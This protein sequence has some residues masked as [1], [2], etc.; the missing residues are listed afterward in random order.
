[1]ISIVLQ[2]C[3]VCGRVSIVSLPCDSCDRTVMS[4]PMTSFRRV[5]GVR[6]QLMEIVA[7]R[8]L[9]ERNSVIVHRHVL[10]SVRFGSFGLVRRSSGRVD[11]PSHQPT[12]YE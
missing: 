5:S 10:G 6:H 3:D 7:V 1:M 2:P 4:L 8:V 9:Y 12:L 11:G